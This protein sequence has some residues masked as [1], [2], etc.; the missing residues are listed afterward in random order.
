M[1]N[2]QN[3]PLVTLLRMEG[4]CIWKP[5]LLTVVAMLMTLGMQGQPANRASGD[6]PVEESC[7]NLSNKLS[8]IIGK[9]RISPDVRELENALNLCEEIR[10]GRLATTECRQLYLQAAQFVLD[11]PFSEDRDQIN[12]LV[13]K[14]R[15]ATRM[16]MG[17]DLNR[18]PEPTR[19]LHRSE[20]LKKVAVF[21]KRLRINTGEGNHYLN[22][23]P[24]AGAG[25]LIFAGQ[26]PDTITNPVKRQEYKAA[27]E[28]NAA[29]AKDARLRSNLARI[30]AD[31]VQQ[32]EKFVLRNYHGAPE[33]QGEMRAAL[34][35]SGFEKERIEKLLKQV[36]AKPN[37]SQ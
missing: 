20:V 35:E 12:A 33:T 28:T 24:P 5:L 36:A 21:A 34:E 11:A 7:Q 32:I 19:H 30:L 10:Q 1:T 31:E 18:I 15:T 27:L 25:Q 16:L 23:M 29:K 17:D 4:T 2:N 14:Q 3:P 6:K 9:W 8:Q 13:K 22:V 26:N 37:S